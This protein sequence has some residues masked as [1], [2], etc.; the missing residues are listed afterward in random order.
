MAGFSGMSAQAPTRA[1]L[2]ALIRESGLLTPK[3]LN[4]ALAQCHSEDPNVILSHLLKAGLITEYQGRELY[5]GRNKGF[6][7]GKY[8]VLEPLATGGMGL[9]LHCEHIYMHHHVA[10]K[11]LPKELNDDTSAVT[12]FYREARAAAAVK[13]P[14]IVQAFDVGQEGAWH[15]L[16]MEF[17]DG[18]N[19]H[20]LITRHGALSE[21]RAAHYIAQ[22]ATGLQAIMEN[23]LVHRDLKPGNLV[24]ARDNSI[25]VVDL[26]LAR[27]LDQR[28]DDL[29]RQFDEE[30]VLGTADFI[31]PEQALH[32]H[33]VDI[34]ADIYSLGMTFYFLLTGKFPF[35]AAT[36]AGKLMSHQTK[37]PKALLARRPDI[38]P[39]LDAIIT[40]MI[41]KRRED[42]YQT[43]QEVV[44][45]LQP[46]T[47]VPLPLPD[48]E[49]F[50]PTTGVFAIPR[51]HSQEN[52]STASG[53]AV[54]TL[55]T[56][57]G[58]AT[59]EMA[60]P[61]PPTTIRPRASSDLDG[62]GQLQEAANFSLS[63]ASREIQSRPATSP[64]QQW[65]LALLIAVP[66]L[67]ALAVVL[68][69]FMRTR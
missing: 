50:A 47:A 17:V 56:S 1:S 35:K 31:S 25:K 69:L 39:E 9:V 11:L 22:A 14:N 55:V 24:L 38:S 5:I 15:C 27:F 49:W 58:Q 13:H 2:L 63:Q 41:Q 34:R 45:A 30:R 53:E 64:R 68:W 59:E 26:G 7:I 8:K 61:E 65:K 32:S 66:I 21:V 36:V 33:D 28:S 62:L 6:F 48:D 19:L 16:V 57:P 52:G 23:D 43:P 3:Q 54:S 40:R 12:R 18:V 4:K 37:M 10:L 60:A 46:W 51:V 20:K 29:T 42:R 44:E 67:L